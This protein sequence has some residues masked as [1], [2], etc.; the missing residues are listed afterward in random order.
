M[1]L[2]GANSAL[3]MHLVDVTN[4]ATTAENRLILPNAL[5]NFILINI[6]LLLRAVSYPVDY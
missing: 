6:I 3:S 4:G 2:E 5:I 1:T